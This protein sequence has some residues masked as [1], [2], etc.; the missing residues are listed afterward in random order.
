M[1]TS[2]LFYTLFRSYKFYIIFITTTLFNPQKAHGPYSVHGTLQ[3][4]CS[5]HSQKGLLL[6]GKAFCYNKVKLQGVQTSMG[7]P[8]ALFMTLSCMSVDEHILSGHL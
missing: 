4:Y 7:N 2:V 8:E 5:Y 3:M 6:L 1:K